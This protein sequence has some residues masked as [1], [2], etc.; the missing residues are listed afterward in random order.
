[1]LLILVMTALL[2]ILIHQVYNSLAFEK[3]LKK[4]KLIG[5]GQF[6][7]VFEGKLNSISPF[8]KIKNVA[9]KTIK[10]DEAG[11]PK[12]MVCLCNFSFA[13]LLLLIDYNSCKIGNN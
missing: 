8:G 3:R 10:N 13:S 1:M 4:G 12:L 7:Y 9:I 6:S 2:A 5:E 11:R